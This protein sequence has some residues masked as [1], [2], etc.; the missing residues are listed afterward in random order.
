MKFILSYMK[1]TWLFILITMVI[2]FIGTFLE[3]LIP[4]VLE[5]IIDSVAP[6]KSLKMV[7]AWGSVMVIL[8][9]LCRFFNKTANQRAVKSARDN[10]YRLRQ[11]LFE[12]TI[13]LSSDNIDHI[14]LPSLISRLTS[15][16][17]NVLSFM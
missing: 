12:K 8:A 10:I 14:T 4:Y 11:D 6:R 1:K 7:I 15:D 3:L 17:Y 13:Y 9:V 16:S 2:K 5:Y